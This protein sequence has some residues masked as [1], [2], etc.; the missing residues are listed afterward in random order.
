MYTKMGHGSS[1]ARRTSR[2]FSSKAP[3][4][5]TRHPTT[6]RPA[7]AMVVPAVR[8]T[9]YPSPFMQQAI[10]HLPIARREYKRCHYE[11][12][13]QNNVNVDLRC[14]RRLGRLAPLPV[15]VVQYILLYLPTLTDIVS[16]ATASYSL[17]FL[18]LRPGG[19]YNVLATWIFDR[20]TWHTAN[21]QTAL[22]A[23]RTILDNHAHNGD[24]AAASCCCA[25]FLQSYFQ[26]SGERTA[27]LK[28]ERETLDVMILSCDSEIRRQKKALEQ[29]TSKVR[30]LGLV[31]SIF[32]FAVVWY[33][34]LIRL[35][36]VVV[37]Y[38]WA[39]YEWLF[40]ARLGLGM[41]ARNAALGFTPTMYTLD[42]TEGVS[43]VVMTFFTFFCLDHL[44]SMVYTNKPR[45]SQ[46]LGVLLC[47]VATYFLI[48]HFY[49]PFIQK[50]TYE[51][52]TPLFVDGLHK[53]FISCH[54]AV[55]LWLAVAALSLAVY[56][57][58]AVGAFVL[59]AYTFGFLAH[60]PCNLAGK[61]CL[62]KYSSR[63]DEIKKRRKELEARVS[64]VSLRL[65]A[66]R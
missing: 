16:A 1:K 56:G 21:T 24:D 10:Q 8:L 2:K 29:M 45:R 5:T 9:S 27:R 50:W 52:A 33:F 4:T 57:C 41:A 6:L 15:E 66:G 34:Y 36:G 46:V 31:M 22:T 32:M 42:W 25:C 48:V 20:I 64:E 37:S 47:T 11:Q 40:V 35:S 44:C 38:V 49:C 39:L 26:S 28:K 58:G 53:L 60:R 13:E 43:A 51:L 3:A 17:W 30:N 59:C 23:F 65:C 61:L 63:V 14:R 55:Y 19:T 18:A 62:D 12:R 54:V 7:P